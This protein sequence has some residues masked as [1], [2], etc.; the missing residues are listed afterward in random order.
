MGCAFPYGSAFHLWEVHFTYDYVHERGS[1]VL[2]IVIFFI[3]SRQHAVIKVMIG[4]F[5]VMGGAFLFVQQ[6]YEFLM[7]YP[8]ISVF[9][10]VT[11]LGWTCWWILVQFSLLIVIFV[12]IKQQSTIPK[13]SKP[14]LHEHSI[15]PVS[16]CFFYFVKFWLVL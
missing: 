6:Q 8:F 16:H 5:S 11:V 9:R 12:Q 13:C 14:P 3:C 7:I 15:H 4:A 2:V 1:I 10:M